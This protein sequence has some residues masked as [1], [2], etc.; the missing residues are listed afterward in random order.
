MRSEVL[1]EMGSFCSLFALPGG[2]SEPVLASAMECVG[3]KCDF[4]SNLH[5]IEG[6]GQDVVAAGVNDLITSG[7]HPLFSDWR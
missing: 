4:L 6:L 2:Y 3:A 7:A 5:R 1:S